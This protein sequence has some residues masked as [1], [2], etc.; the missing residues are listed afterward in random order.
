MEIKLKKVIN[1]GYDLTFTINRNDIIGITGANCNEVIKLLNLEY[2]PEG[3]ITFNDLKV[4]EK[5]IYNIT[6]HIRTFLFL[7]T[8]CSDLSCLLMLFY[9]W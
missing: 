3:S 8:H 6:S 2:I 9:N 1:N 7:E 4:T 5:N